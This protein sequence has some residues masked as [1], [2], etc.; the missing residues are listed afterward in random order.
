MKK[1]ALVIAPGRGT[2]NKPE[3]GYL[4]R[5]HSDK[6]E[7]IAKIDDYRS[8]K[9]QTTISDLDGRDAYSIKEHTRGDN[10]SPL[11]YG[12]AYAD[13]LAINRDEYDIVGVTGNSM[14]WYI[15]LACAGALSFDNALDL[16]N[17]M[18]GL[19]QDSLIGGQ[20]IYPFIDQ[21]WRMQH[22]QKQHL[23]SLIEE[24]NAREDCTLAVSIMLGG[25]LVYG[26]NQ[27]A[28]GALKDKL[29]PLDDRF[30]LILPNHAA[31]H[32]ALQKPIAAKALQI[33]D[34]DMFAN[35]TTPLID[36]RGHIWRS[37]ATQASAIF[38]YTLGHQVYEYYDFTAAVQVSVKE[39]A[40]DCLIILGPGTTLGGAVAQS[41]IDINW[42]GM[43]SKAAFS[44][45][46]K[47]SPY[48]IAMGIDEQ[49]QLVT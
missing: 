29:P 47:S 40:P 17:T 6:A 44:A 36:G 32:T 19:M 43:D 15:A 30:P 7:L 37:H 31:F 27:A 42:E 34:A 14:G 1:R 23:L 25:M 13:Y 9:G 45:R 49:R 26:G 22:D 35:P 28:L 4:S 12:C 21:D 11:I 18:G 46:Q 24:I 5:H 39:Y 16:I 41:L 8:A 38:D 2:Y 33:F 20:L 48:I 3:L 10:A